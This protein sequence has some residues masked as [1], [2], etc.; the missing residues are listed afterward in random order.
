MHQSRRDTTMAR[1]KQEQNPEQ[2]V[3]RPT[4]YSEKLADRICELVATHPIGY[5][6]IRNMYPDIPRMG[7][8]REWRIRYPEFN[9]K[10]L[11][12]K[13]FQAE[14]MVED[15]DDLLPDDIKTYIDERGNERIDSP[16]A[17]MLI[18]KINNRKW[19]A[20]RLSPKRFGDYK[21]E[22]SDDKKKELK[23]EMLSILQDIDAKN[24]K[25]Y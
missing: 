2:P 16:T 1:K 9:A 22:N 14:I 24:K 12:A 19:M 20:A 7:V 6:H 23:Q 25:D 10:Y 13:R 18:A 3:G 8:V 11:D 21:E 15:I 5:E 17:S 4:N